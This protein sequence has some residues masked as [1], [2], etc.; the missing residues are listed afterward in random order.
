MSAHRTLSRTVATAALALVAAL[1]LSGCAAQGQDLPRQEIVIAGGVSGG[2]Y[3]GY[4]AALAEVLGRE[5]RVDATALSTAGSLENLRLVGSGEALLGFAQSDTAA[6]AIAGTGPFSEPLPIAGVARLYEEYVHVV[7]R[8]DSDVDQLSDLAGRAISLGAPNSGV[9]AAAARILAEAEVD[10]EQIDNPRLGL[11][12][13]LAALRA[14]EIEGFFWV[15]GLP[16]PGLQ[17][18]SQEVPI[19]LVSIEH[20]LVDRLNERH[21]GVYRTAEFPAGLYGRDEVSVTMT[22]PN[23]LIVNEAVP[24]DVVR[25]A[26]AAVFRTRAEV[27]TR[28]PTA[29]LLDRRLAIF[30]APLELHPGAAAYYRETKH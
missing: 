13:S 6:D 23:Y 29:A 5:L 18:F 25:D 10:P 30:T 19:R 20:R 14:G 21:G 7:V 22:V 26:L 2:I 24:D 16:T 15:G 4:G 1:G 17:E 27:A 28:V 9:A 12:D 3:A 8:A 11:D